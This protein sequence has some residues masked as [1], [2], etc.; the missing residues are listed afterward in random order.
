MA[1]TAA[2]TFTCASLAETLGQVE[3]FVRLYG[4]L[5]AVADRI[6]E[7]EAEK[8]ERDDQIAALTRERDELRDKN[9]KL[10]AES[11]KGI[12]PDA[13]LQFLK[14]RVYCVGDLDRLLPL[15]VE[16]QGEQQ[17]ATRG[18]NGGAKVD[19]EDEKQQGSPP[20]SVLM[21]TVQELTP[22]AAPALAPLFAANSPPPSPTV[23]VATAP[24]PAP[25]TP[26]TAARPA[27]GP[28]VKE[29]KTPPARKEGSVAKQHDDA[30]QHED[31]KPKPNGDAKQQDEEEEQPSDDEEESPVRTAT[32]TK[33]R[34]GVPL[35]TKRKRGSTVS[36][37][38]PTPPSRRASPGRRGRPP[39]CANTAAE[40]VEQR[41]SKRMR[42]PRNVTPRQILQWPQLP[43]TS[44]VQA[45]GTG[46]QGKGEGA[47][48]FQTLDF[49]VVASLEQ[50]KPWDTMCSHRTRWL[51]IP[52]LA[53]RPV[54]EWATR[55]LKAQYVRRQAYWERLHW[56]PESCCK[57]VQWEKYKVARQERATLADREWK[58][59]YAESVRLMAEDLLPEDVW[60]DPALWPLPEQP[61]L[62]LPKSV[63]LHAQIRLA[64]SND[65]VRLY[66]VNAPTHHPFFAE[67]LATVY[68]TKQNAPVVGGEDADAVG[69]N[70]NSKQKSMKKGK[71][72]GAKTS[73]AKESGGL[74]KAN[75]VA[76][77]EDEP[78]AE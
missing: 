57:G 55:C 23:A 61:V 52:D 22:A 44:D 35:W 66:F 5:Q 42:K 50:T 51:R 40:E 58:S 14:R 37:R 7:L 18:K 2:L 39:S 46:K 60:C 41:P 59:I 48:A 32:P 62:L 45:D 70:D 15:L 54:L 27:S 20:S 12:A 29:D 34:R 64:D 13:I 43:A 38:S 19:T 31:S 4:S 24:L 33:R 75:V 9:K 8:Q 17:Q 3:E 71:R 53:S 26:S 74:V 30:K 6:V 10:E 69:E 28:S 72:G 76:D 21:M 77:D 16:C 56:L 63:D 67:G 49:R 65:P 25:A 78:E 11:G 1:K 68:P 47:P 36:K 73:G